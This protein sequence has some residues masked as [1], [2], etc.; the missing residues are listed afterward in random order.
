[1]LILTN[2]KI[3]SFNAIISE[4]ASKAVFLDEEMQF[5]IHTENLNDTKMITIPYNCVESFKSLKG[6]PAIH[7][8]VVPSVLDRFASVFENCKYFTLK[9]REDMKI[10]SI[11]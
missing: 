9:S 10:I 2:K 11:I 8:L 4:K 5:L 1:M 3:L 7:I 6:E